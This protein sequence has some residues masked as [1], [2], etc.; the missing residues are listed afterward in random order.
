ML[1]EEGLKTELE[2]KGIEALGGAHDSGKH[3][4]DLPQDLGDV[5][6]ALA[7]PDAGR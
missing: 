7:P 6:K 3:G 1:G 4:L 2:L 5:C